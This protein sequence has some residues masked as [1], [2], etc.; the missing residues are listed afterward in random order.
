MC[1]IIDVKI[2]YSNQKDLINQKKHQMSLAD[3][4]LLEWDL[5]IAEQDTW[6]HYK[7][8]RIIGYAPIGRIVY[9]VVFTEEN[10][11][12]HIISL[13][14]ADRQEVRKYASQI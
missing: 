7:D 11:H 3:A 1:T 12:Y 10:D 5:L 13:R 6:Y 4:S 2:T 9:C 8:I 14:K